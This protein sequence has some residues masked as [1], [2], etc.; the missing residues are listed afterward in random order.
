MATIST[1]ADTLTIRLSRR[2]K[3]AAAH[4]DVRVPLAAIRDVRVLPDALAAARRLRRGALPMPG[5]MRIGIWRGRG[6]HDV[7]VARRGMPAVCVTL[8]GGRRDEI[9]VSSPDAAAMA[10]RIR[11]AALHVRQRL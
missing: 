11:A 10:E 8:G 2:E 4:G 6:R 7:V 3:I 9:V 1:S 5:R